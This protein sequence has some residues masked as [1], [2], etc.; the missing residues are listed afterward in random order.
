MNKL[1]RPIPAVIGKKLDDY[2]QPVREKLESLRS[3]VLNVAADDPAVGELN[4][5][6]KWGQLA[7][8]PDSTGSGTTIRADWHEK[9]PDELSLYVHCGTNLVDQYRNLFP[10]VFEYDGNRKVGIPLSANLVKGEV[11]DQL[12]QCVSM[13]LRYHID[14]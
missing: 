11:A 14:K 7:W 5:T 10:E 2:P 8:L 1:E 4:E 13:A 6:L 9:A 12:G 3:L